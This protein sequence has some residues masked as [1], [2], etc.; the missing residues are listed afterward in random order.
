MGDDGQT[1]E[2]VMSINWPGVITLALLG[3]IILYAIVAEGIE[4]IRKYRKPRRKRRHLDEWW[5]LTVG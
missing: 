4:H 1:E 3:G 5:R 2:G